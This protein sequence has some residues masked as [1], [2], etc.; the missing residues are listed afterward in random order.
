MRDAG[1]TVGGFYAHFRSKRALDAEVLRAAITRMRRDWFARL[2]NRAGIDWLAPAVKRYLSKTH[3]DAA[4]DGCPL[5]AVVSELTRADKSTRKVL[6]E[7]FETAAREFAARAPAT[8]GIDSRQ[9]AVATLALCVG[10]L[11]L[12]RAL[13]GDPASDEVLEACVKW[14][15]PELQQQNSRGG[16]L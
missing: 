5:P 13:R 12:A 4:S 2:E 16:G 15:L 11:T 10:G 6:A 9:R 7:S 8:P 1:L 3:R 14:A